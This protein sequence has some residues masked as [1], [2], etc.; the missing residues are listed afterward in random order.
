VGV[1]FLAHH[2]ADPER[3][4]LSGTVADLEAGRDPGWTELR[5]WPHAR[6][7]KATRQVRAFFPRAGQPAPGI[8]DE[9]VCLRG[10][11]ERWT[12]E[13]L[14]FLVD[15]FP[16][17]C[18]SF[19]LGGFDQYSPLLEESVEGLALR[20]RKRVEA[21]FWYPTL[22]LNLEVKKA[23]PV[24]G[25]RFLFTRLRTKQI[26]NGRYDLEV[27]VWDAEGD[28]VALSHHVC[29]AV[30]AERNVASRRKGGE[31]AKL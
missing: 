22:L 26:R 14:G 1:S 21:P 31:G 27:L 10:A 11:D 2:A 13:K 12:G 24:E 4:P 20:E 18:E 9:W 29:F 6:F 19:M 16:Q 23:L 30:S 17:V 5:E 3:I 28:L 8:Y 15:L 7:R 25:V